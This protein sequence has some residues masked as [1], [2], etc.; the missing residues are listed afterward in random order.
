MVMIVKVIFRIIECTNLVSSSSKK[1]LLLF[2][3]VKGFLF[4]LV[5]LPSERSL[6]F[7]PCFTE[8]PAV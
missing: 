3:L 2:M 5:G 4:Q 1:I 8:N 6:I 7:R